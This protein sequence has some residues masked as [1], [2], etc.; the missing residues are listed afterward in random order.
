MEGGGGVGGDKKA[1]CT[2]GLRGITGIPVY[3][4]I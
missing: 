3:H 2:V 1:D 4:G